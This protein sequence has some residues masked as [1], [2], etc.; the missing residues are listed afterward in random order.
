MKKQLLSFITSI[1]LTTSSCAYSDTQDICVMSFNVRRDGKESNPHYL[2]KNRTPL[3]KDMLTN[4]KPDIL[5]LQEAGENQIIDIENIVGHN[6]AWVGEGR[7]Q[8]GVVGWFVSV[9]EH[10]PIFYNRSRF[11]LLTYETFWLNPTKTPKKSGW[12]AWLNRICTWA[13]FMDLQS[14]TVLWIF[15][16]HLDHM[17]AQ[18]RSEGL[19]LII[20]EIEHKTNNQET[21][22]LMGDFNEP[23]ASGP[24]AD[25]IASNQYKM[26]NTKNIAQKIKGPHWTAFQKGWEGSGKSIDH[27]LINTPEAFTITEHTTW[28]HPE[29]KRASDHNPVFITLKTDAQTIN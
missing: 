18:A 24:L 7:Q 22:L 10:T 23:L 28:V 26:I 29:N 21:A 14:N 6:Y 4:I 12:G 3:I 20:K 5:C 2:W 8:G 25:I 19:K 9:D 11:K 15:N 16:T 13:K 1:I 17:S 27:I